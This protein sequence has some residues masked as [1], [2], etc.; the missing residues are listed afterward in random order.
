MADGSH[1]LTAPDEWSPLLT[2]VGLLVEAHAGLVAT[3]EKRLADGG[4][5]T[6]QAFEIL[7]RLVRSPDHRLRMSDLAAQTTLTASGLTR[8]VDRLQ[9]DGLVA[10]VACAED[11]RVSY[12]ELTAAGEKAIRAALPVHQ[13]HLGEV[14]ADALSPE[15][16]VELDRIMRRLRDALNPAAACASLPGGTPEAAPPG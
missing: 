12:A 5:V 3:F 10:R 8:A 9:R 6:G 11:R 1:T 16:L 2:T 14:F 15:D 7:L 13:A 4:H